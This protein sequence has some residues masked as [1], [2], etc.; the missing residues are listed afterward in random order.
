MIYFFKY[1]ASIKT[2]G[3]PSKED[4][5]TKTSPDKGQ[6]AKGQPVNKEKE[7]KKK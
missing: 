5:K 7:T 4:D 1:K 3:N 2:F 6:P